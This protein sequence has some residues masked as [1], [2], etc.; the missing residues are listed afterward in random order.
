[1]DARDKNYDASSITVLEGLQAVR[2]RPG[3]YIGD[4]GVTGLHH[5]VY[6][7]VDNSIDE[8]MAGYCSEIH[9]RIL[10]DGGISIV[11]NGRG[12]PIQ[13]HE[14]ESKKQGREVSALEVV[15]T[16][17]HAGGK[18]DK[19][20][21]KVSGGLHGVGVSCVNALSEK[22]VARV[23][24]N[25][26]IYSMEFSR[27]VPLTPLQ[28]LGSTDRQGTEITF[29]PDSR[30]F[31]SCIF[32]RSILIKRLRELAFLNRGITII[33][34]DD[35]DESFSKVTFFYEGG[36]RSFVSYLNQNKESLFPDPIYISGSRSGDDGDIEFEAALQWNSGYTEL[37][38]SYANNIPTRQGGTHL[39]GFS[40]A[41]TRVLNTYIKVHNLAKT[42]K[43]SLTGE[44]IR[45]GLTGVVSVKVPNPQFEGQ[46]KQKLGNSDVGSVAQ[47]I[48]G[49]ALATFFDENP[50]IAKLIVDKVFVAAQAR[51]AAKKA[52]ELTLRK[53]AL[54]SARLPGKLI[55]CLEKDPE[56]CEMYI[57]EGDSAGG[58]AK[59]GRDRQFQAILPIRG[60]ILNVEKARLQKIFQNQEIGTIIAALG[61]G[62]GS[63]NFNLS[64]LRYKRIII[65]TD[66]DVDGSHIRTLLLTFFYRHMTALIENEC[67]YIAQPPLYKISKKKDFRYILSEKEMDDYLLTLGIEDSKLVFKNTNRELSGDALDRF[68]KLILSVES[69]IT[70][71]EKKAIPFSEF[72]EMYKENQGYPVYYYP[73]TENRGGRYFYSSEEKDLE[74]AQLS[75]TNSTKVIELYKT[76][77]FTEIQ[78]EL[79]DYGLDIRHYLIS[80]DLEIVITNGDS[81]LLPYTCFTLKEVVDYLKTLGR[82]GIEIQRY[83]GLGEMNADQLWDTTMNP[84]QRTLVRVSLKDAVEADHIFTM[85]MGEEVPPRRE[86]IES[87]A[88]SIRM[89]NLDI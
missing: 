23:F 52:R 68:V 31:S 66:A 82:K 14:K 20:S 29:Y 28:C 18:F 39:T 69:F 71:L 58:S 73:A 40:T 22:L 42:D 5:L 7:V 6:E 10:A 1:M 63:D 27:G 54:D 33:F 50:Q 4:T 12:I 83:K 75:D 15:L 79:R 41:L 81:S 35:R 77:I 56:K 84:E 30:I 78:D 34:D 57:V 46:T 17:L 11:D 9:V 72:I 51:E 8:A 44:D 74:L 62:I 37:I 64:K 55:D 36:I 24:K 48:T 47:Q 85:L 45:E 65:M 89:N 86:F 61:C 87:H 21:Y 76:A 32:D 2:E 26:Q 67:V 70:T 60:K 38:Y 53:S 88:L 80:K 19:D 43:L 49:E 13:V 25:S 16:V 59:Q 3:M